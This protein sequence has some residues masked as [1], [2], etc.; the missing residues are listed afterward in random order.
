MDSSF[1]L[2]KY[3]WDAHVVLWQKF[4]GSIL[5]IY[6]VIR[7]ARLD[8]TVHKRCRPGPG[9]LSVASTQTVRMAMAA[10]AVP[11]SFLVWGFQFY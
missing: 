5:D 3:V 10:A 1:W 9:G 2:G 4:G 8:A 11:N 6:G 7:I